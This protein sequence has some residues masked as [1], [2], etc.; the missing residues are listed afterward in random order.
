MNGVTKSLFLVFICFV[1][2]ATTVGAPKKGFQ[3]PNLNPFKSKRKTNPPIS[4]RLSDKP[5]RSWSIPKLPKMKVPQF[6][7]TT[8][9]PPKR[10]SPSTWQKM[11]NGTKKF[12][13]KTKDALT[14]WSKSTPAKRS[15]R[16]ARKPKKKSKS[17]FP[18]SKP[19]K[20]RSQNVTDYLKQDKIVP[21]V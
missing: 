21:G 17:W 10:K 9:R 7:R 13:S 16:T 19:K 12:F 14:P 2:S 3:F 18:W 6:S 11:N 8:K 5:K 4:A 20:K 15:A 1:F